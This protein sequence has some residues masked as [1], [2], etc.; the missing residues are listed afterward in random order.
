[1]A[2]VVED[3]QKQFEAAAERVKTTKRPEGAPAPT[4]DM[5]LKLYSLFKQATA[6]DVTGSQPWKVQV[7]ARAK[8]DAWNAVKGKSKEDAMKEYIAEVEAQLTFD[9]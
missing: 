9:K 6:G 8:W 4:N 2:A 1:M 7:E 5:K 3:L